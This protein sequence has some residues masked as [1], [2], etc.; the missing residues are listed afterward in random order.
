[1]YYFEIRFVPPTC[2]SPKIA[3]LS[4]TSYVSLALG[5]P[6]GG[7]GL[8]RHREGFS[9]HLLLRLTTLRHPKPF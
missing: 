8:E 5:N 1:M 2:L 4:H 3:V 7:G 9:F 6:R